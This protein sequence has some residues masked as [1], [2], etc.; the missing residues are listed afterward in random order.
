[1][2]AGNYAL[3]NAARE[4]WTLAGSEPSY[5]CDLESSIAWALPLDVRAVPELSVGDVNA[6]A[7]SADMARP[8]S[9]QDR[10]LRGC[11]LAYRGKGIIFVDSSDMPDE[12][13]FTLAHELAHFLLDYRSPRQRALAALGS[14][15]SAVL[16]GLRPPTRQER[17]HAVLE[18]VPLGVL[19]HLMERPAGGIPSSAVFF[20]E[21]RADRLALELLA[22]AALVLE[23][24]GSM[25]RT[26]YEERRTRLQAL[27]AGEHGLPAGIA[28]A[29]AGTLL[30]KAGGPSFRDWLTGEV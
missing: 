27:L 17:L 14:G 15:I 12:R 20:I 26:G 3:E 8:F 28:Q 25:Q 4:F 2:I 7:L 23:K 9:G 19:T 24:H 21:G 6:A 22:P 16:D 1:M 5:P 13:R 29:Y 10:R 11:L 18:A 30:Y